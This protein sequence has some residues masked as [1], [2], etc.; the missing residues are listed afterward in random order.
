MFLLTGAGTCLA[1]T[2]ALCACQACTCVSK[3]VLRKSARLAYSVLFFLALVLAWLLRDFAKPLIEKI[4]CEPL[5]D[6]LCLL[7]WTYAGVNWFLDS[8][9][10]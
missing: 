3:E 10:A 8:S 6:C 2:A 9:P 7:V 1:S 4:P 5:L